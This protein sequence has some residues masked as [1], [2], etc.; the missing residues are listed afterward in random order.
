MRILVTGGTGYIGSH[1][2]VELVNDGH[3]VV[4][5]D[6]LVNSSSRVMDRIETITGVMPGF[7]EVDIRDEA[8][9]EQVI[10]GAG[11]DAVVHFAGLKAVGESVQE[12]LEYYNNN[13]GGTMTLCRVLARHDVRTVVF[14]S[15]ATVYGDPVTLPLTE[16]APT[17]KPAN[18]YG[19]TKLIIEDILKDMHRADDRWNIILLRYFNPVGAHESG[20][21]GED[22]SGVPNNLMPYIAQ[23]AVERRPQLT[24]HG[25]DY[26]TDDGTGVRDYIHVVD[27]AEGHVAALEHL[28]KTPDIHIYN[29]GT[30][31]GTS[32]LELI[33]TFEQVTGAKVPY[34]IGPRRGGDIAANW[35]DA[36]K[37]SRDLGW[38]ADRDLAQM[39]ADTW[40]WQSKNPHGLRVGG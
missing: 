22:P 13:V 7:H 18:P 24:V 3:D 20:L 15:S 26:A 14:S 4:V 19:R 29:L 36:S 17:A 16:R 6:N 31:R 35:C 30:G 1:A 11:F 34:V 8:G 37:A 9:L 12:P 40:N 39:C 21:I 38:T 32:V 2:V 10:A 28:A 5:I 33:E 25:N 27:L 23:V